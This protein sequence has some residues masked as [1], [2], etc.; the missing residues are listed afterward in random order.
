[1]EF[2]LAGNAHI[3]PVWLWRWLE[4][5]WTVR[6]TVR[7]IIEL[8]EKYP[9]LTFVFSSSIMYRWLEECEPQL[10]KKVKKFVEEGRWIPVGGWVVEPDSNIPCGESYVRQTL[11]GK[12]YYKEKLGIDTVVGYN[13]D[14]FGHNASLPQI[15]RKSGYKYYI[16]MRPSSHEKNLPPIFFWES[17]DG[18]RVLAYRH[19]IS[20]ALYGNH[21][22]ERL[23][24]LSL[25]PP[26]PVILILFGKGDHG[27]GP[28]YED[29]KTIE[30]LADK[31]K[32]HSIRFASP[33]EF[34][35][36]ILEIGLEIPIVKDE[37]QHHAVGCYSLLSEVKALNRRAEYSLIAAE[38]LS[39]LAYLTAGLSYPRDKLK[40]GWMLTLFCQ[41]HDS[42]AGTCI[43]E[44][45]RDIQ[46]MYGESINIA[47]ESINLAVQKISS[48]VD[49]RDGQ[50]LI[51]FNPTCI[52][53]RFPVEIE[54]W[55]GDYAIL[56]PDNGNPVPIQEVQPSSIAGRKRILFIADVPALGYK[57]YRFTDICEAGKYRYEGVL[58]VSGTRIENDYFAVE[59]NPENGGIEMLYDKRIGIN[60][61]KGC[62]GSPIVLR[63]ESD[64]WGHG[65]S[66]YRCE[67]GRVREAE[68]SL[69]ESGPVRA[70]LSVKARF[71][72]SVI[73]QYISLY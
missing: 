37:L 11:Y 55:P 18:S 41:F 50:Y 32:G 25:N 72:N 62:G 53:T 39:V 19:P 47:Y 71:S 52:H 63:D 6:C 15:L 27:G 33:E 60:T 65:V 3:D 59:V 31:I 54:P 28:I 49:T 57:S 61:L 23:E 66:T 45:Y 1:M 73:W 68:I 70:T 64:T 48:M 42:L 36:R 34:F 67:E 69:I 7:R 46:N 20:Y 29:M 5:Y 30:K 21:L 10:F 8:M 58:E 44:A 51:V 26:L 14:S 17:P 35:K 12:S 16:F 2:I 56:D 4:G 43:P 22:T 13:I 24:R 40:R 38:N 9:S